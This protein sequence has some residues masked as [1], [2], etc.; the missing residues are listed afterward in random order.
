[1]WSPACCVGQFATITVPGTYI[2]SVDTLVCT[3][4]DTFV[5]SAAPAPSP[6]ITGND[7]YCNNDLTT[8]GVSGNYSS[9]TWSNGDTTANVNVGIGTYTV[10]V[11]DPNS[12]CTGTSPAVT[13]TNSNPQ[14]TINL[15]DTVC[16]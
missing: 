12:G 7:F 3:M 9:Y 4:V 6:I 16:P 14:A 1:S 2:V 8:L 15:P 10:T 5:I 11:T 13:V